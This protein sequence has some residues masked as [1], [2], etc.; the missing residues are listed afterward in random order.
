MASAWFVA[1]AVVLVLAVLSLAACS[2]DEDD[3]AGTTAPSTTARR[4]EPM[5]I[6]ERVVIAAAPGAEPIAT[7]EVIEGSTLGGA[8]FCAG[9]TIADS[10]GSPDPAVRLIVQTITCPDGTV[11]LRFTPD[12]P[13]G[14][15]QTGSWTIV[16]GSGAYE[17]L[18]GSGEMEVVYDPDPD[19]PAQ[20]TFTGTATR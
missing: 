11:S 3:A 19:A 20:V 4:G 12:E 1:R 17:G 13:Q 9:G 10:H 5:V 6:R 14:L 18:R 15:S 7:G 8:R 16:S 2:G